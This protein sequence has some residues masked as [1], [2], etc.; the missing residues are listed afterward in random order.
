MGPG[1]PAERGTCG[2]S[3]LQDGPACCRYRAWGCALQASGSQQVPR[4]TSLPLDHTKALPVASYP[5]HFPGESWAG[6]GQG[7]G[8][9][10][11]WAVAEPGYAPGCWL[12]LTALGEMRSH[13]LSPHPRP[14]LPVPPQSRPTVQAHFEQSLPRTGSFLPLSLNSSS[15]L[16]SQA[17]PERLPEH[18]RHVSY[19]F[20]TPGFFPVDGLPDC[21]GSGPSHH[22]ALFRKTSS[23]LSSSQTHT[24]FSH[25]LFNNPTQFLFI[26]QSVQFR[27]SVLSDSLQPH[28]LQHTRPPCP[29][30]S[31][32]ACSN[33]CPLSQ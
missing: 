27:C 9:R 26:F 32:R 21:R 33:S 17:S 18:L 10:R 3:C 12:L 29:S 16:P 24:T 7:A 15:E 31:S 5:D 25:T 28:G 23:T 11:S 14:L 6:K 2:L 13:Q 22:P 8:P 4:L 20:P 19:A 30:L 1:E